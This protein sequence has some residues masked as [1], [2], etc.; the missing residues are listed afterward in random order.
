MLAIK[1]KVGGA[2]DAFL[3]VEE[4]CF[5]W[6]DFGGWVFRA[7]IAVVV[8]HSG[9]ISI[10]SYPKIVLQIT[11]IFLSDDCFSCSDRDCLY[12]CYLLGGETTME[13]VVIS[14]TIGA[15]RTFLGLEVEIDKRRS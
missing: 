4:G 2:C 12:S 1:V 10:I 13:I 7:L 14:R 11:Q 9:Y 5:Y 6:T 8:E 15:S 3:S